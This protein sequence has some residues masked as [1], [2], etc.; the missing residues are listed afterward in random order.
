M[1]FLIHLLQVFVCSDVHNIFIE[2]KNNF[3]CVKIEISYFQFEF[4]R[5]ILRQL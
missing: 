3:E 2:I 1:Y 5:L 4:I